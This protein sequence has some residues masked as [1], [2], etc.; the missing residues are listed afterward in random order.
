MNGKLSTLGDHVTELELLSSNQDNVSDLEK[1][2]KSLEEDNAYLREKVD[3]A[4]NRSRAY[5][6]R[7]LH[8]P[9]Q[10]EGRDIAGFM[11]QLI[12]SLL[13]KENFPS[14]L[15]LDKVHH[16][17]T[18]C[19]QDTKAGPRPI[20]VKLHNIQEK[21][22]I[23]RLA[24][25]KKEL[26]FKCEFTSFPTSAPH[27]CRDVGSSIRSRKNFRT[28]IENIPY[29]IQPGLEYLPMAYPLCSTVQVMPT[30]SSGTSQ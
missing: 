5:N 3:E 15:I 24:Q 7:F 8:V 27:Y 14:L 13:G 6:L 22:K 23:L 4:E 9:E 28:E 10:A 21:V 16:T 19:H 17:P 12:P 29:S 2:V 30:P 18:F 26:V 20:L 11:T 1:Q 25:E